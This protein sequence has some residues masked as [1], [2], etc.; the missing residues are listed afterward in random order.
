MITP[1]VRSHAASVRF[2]ARRLGLV[3]VHVMYQ[4]LGE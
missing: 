2:Y 3:D 1:G 4:W